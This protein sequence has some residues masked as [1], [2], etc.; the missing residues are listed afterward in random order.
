MFVNNAVECK[1]CSPSAA[2]LLI[3]CILTAVVCTPF[4]ESTFKTTY[5][6]TIVEISI[7]MYPISK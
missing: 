1:Q 4:N 7:W 5:V 6:T 3:Y 2:H